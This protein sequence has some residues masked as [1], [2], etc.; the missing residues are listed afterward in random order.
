MNTLKTVFF[1]IALLLLTTG[2]APPTQAKG[3][4]PF[5]SDIYSTMD[6]LSKK[7]P[8]VMGQNAA[9]HNEKVI[10]IRR[11]FSKYR[12]KRMEKRDIAGEKPEILSVCCSDDA[13]RNSIDQ[14]VSLY[15]DY[16]GKNGLHIA[17]TVV[18]RRD[19]QPQ[20]LS[21]RHAKI[22]D[23]DG[24]YIVYS[25]GIVRD[26]STNLEWIAGP[27][28]N[29]TW[30]EA[31]SWVKN[32]K[33]GGGGWRMPTLKELESLYKKGAGPRNMTPFLK[34]KGWWVWSGET[35]GAREARSFS[36]GHGFKGW[37][38]RGNSSSER[39]FAVRSSDRG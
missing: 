36:F 31:N 15:F 10:H 19:C 2:H 11:T 29:I 32:L 39:V 18:N 12:S 38:F 37:M 28:R 27:D 25:N 34:I 7:I 26:T 1:V 5:E 14:G 17:S 3:Q 9:L 33:V 24:V 6:R 8:V 30:T 16:Y 21:T 4:S 13:I 20:A 22:A 23:R 35:V